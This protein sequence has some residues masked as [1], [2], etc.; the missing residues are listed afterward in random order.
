MFLGVL[1]HLAYPRTDVATADR[2]G[3]VGSSTTGGGRNLTQLQGE[4]IP[5]SL[6]HGTSGNGRCPSE[7]EYSP[8]IQSL[9][10]FGPDSALLLQK[11]MHHSLLHDMLTALLVGLLLLESVSGPPVHWKYREVSLKIPQSE[12]HAGH[13]T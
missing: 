7:G 8:K 12:P 5:T 10:S 2:T 4:A 9:P 1:W 13:L 11:F 3:E 6:R